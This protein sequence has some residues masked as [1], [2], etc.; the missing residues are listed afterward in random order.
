MNQISNKATKVMRA[1]RMEVKKFEVRL[2]MLHGLNP[3]IVSPILVLS[4][5]CH[6]QQCSETT[7][8]NVAKNLHHYYHKELLP[9][10]ELGYN[11]S[12]NKDYY[13]VYRVRIWMYLMIYSLNSGAAVYLPVGGIESIWEMITCIKIMSYNTL[14]LS[15]SS[16]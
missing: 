3:I 12:E 11:F 2:H 9:P 16:L 5:S 4:V 10:L 8:S 14:L 7:F 6:P 13:N 1:S 15:C